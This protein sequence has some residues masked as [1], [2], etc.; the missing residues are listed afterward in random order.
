MEQLPMSWFMEGLPLAFLFGICTM[1]F[2][3]KVWVSHIS[4]GPSQSHGQCPGSV[5]W[6]RSQPG[7]TLHSPGENTT[8][9]CCIFFLGKIEKNYGLPFQGVSS[10]EYPNYC[11]S[12]SLLV[13]ILSLPQGRSHPLQLQMPYNI[14]VLLN[15]Q[16][17]LSPNMITWTWKAACKDHI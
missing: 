11:T 5:R 17:V 6:A 1:Y 16:T 13:Y 15:F 4:T 8:G 7:K 9:P 12:C 2:D 3:R 10:R 14:E